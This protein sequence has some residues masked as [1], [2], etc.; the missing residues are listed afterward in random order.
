MDEREDIKGLLDI[1]TAN[2]ELRQKIIK[3][4]EKYYH[5]RTAFVQNMLKK[6]IDINLKYALDNL[7]GKKIKIDS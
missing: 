2:E 4:N 3:Y 1:I 7:N 5:P 6:S